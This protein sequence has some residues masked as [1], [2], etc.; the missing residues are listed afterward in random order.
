VDEGY[1]VAGAAV[2]GA[3]EAVAG[4]VDFLDFFDFFFLVVV[5]DGVVAVVAVVAGATVAV[6]AVVA[7]LSSAN[8]APRDRTATATRAESVFFIT[9]SVF[10]FH[11]W[12]ARGR[13]T[14]PLAQPCCHAL[15]RKEERQ[16]K[17]LLGMV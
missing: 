1:F 16:V 17:G 15:G 8:A 6:L 2:A 13:P 9:S 7:G 3:A 5:V 12:P 10:P 11:L 14:K 4:A